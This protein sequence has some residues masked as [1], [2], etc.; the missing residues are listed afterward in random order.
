M[1]GLV[2]A[3]NL[4]LRELVQTVQSAHVLA[5]RAS[6]AAETLGVGAVLDGQI[7]LVENNVAV[8]VRHGHL[9]RGDEIEVV[10]LAMIHLTLLVGQLAC[11]VARSG[12]HHRGRHDFRV[13]RLAGLVE[14]EVDECALQTGSIADIYGESCT[15]NLHAQVEVDEVVFLGQFPVGQG[16][17]D[18]QVGVHVPV[19]HGVALTAFAQVRLHHVV[20]LGAR[21]LGHFVVGY[22]GDGAEQGGHVFF[23]LL[24]L[25]F[26]LLVGLLHF[27]NLLLDGV[28]LVFLS[29]L[30]QS[31]NLGGHF[32]GL[33]EV[34]V[35]LLL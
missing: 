16:I 4:N 15:G 25:L 5:I 17:L 23:G 10:Y 8:D 3:H 21:A 13:A 6:L 34:C 33:R 7:L 31:A 19:A 27:R 29:F 24:H 28:G 12:I 35:Q 26:Q 20:V 18:V 30:H 32:L 11:A 22:V 1:L 14:E 2:D 9:G